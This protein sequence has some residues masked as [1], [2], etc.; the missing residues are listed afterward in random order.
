MVTEH[1]EDE[2]RHMKLKQEIEEIQRGDWD[3]RLQKE[4]DDRRRSQAFSRSTA[5]GQSK[6]SVVVPK[7]TGL[8][9]PP[10]SRRDGSLKRS[11]SPSST[12]IDIPKT[13]P[14]SLQ[15]QVHPAIITQGRPLAAQPG[16]IN[17]TGQSPYRPNPGLSPLPSQGQP[18]NPFG[19]PVPGSSTGYAGRALIPHG[20]PHGRP[21][22]PMPP[23]PYQQYAQSPSHITPHVTYGVRPANSGQ[24]Q[25]I[26]SPHPSQR[27]G[28]M[29]PPFQVAPQPPAPLQ[30]QQASG[31]APVVPSR[32]G[33]KA[34]IDTQAENISTPL[35]PKPQ[36]MPTPLVLSISKMLSNPSLNSTPVSSPGAAKRLAET[37]W[38]ETPDAAT[39]SSPSRPRSRSVSP[40][41]EQA[42]SPEADTTSKKRRKKAAPNS[43]SEVAASTR[44]AR[45]SRR[46]RGASAASSV[47]ESS[48]RGR[49]RSQSM[50]TAT[51]EHVPKQEPSTPME[52]M[53]IDTPMRAP[54]SA[55]RNI[56]GKRKRSPT[57]TSEQGDQHETIKSTAIP[58]TSVFAVRNFQRLSS[59]VMN[60]IMSHKH[61]SIF[62]NPVRD[63]HAEG[64][65]SMIRRPSDL[66]S[67]KA[68]ISFGSRAANAANVDVDSSVSA[69]QL[70]W[71]E[72][73]VPPKGIV[74]SAQ[75]EKELMR[76]FAN[77]VMFNPGEED[78]VK[79]ARE[80][81]ESA[82]ASLLNF[83]SAEQRTEAGSTST[84]GLRKRAESEIST[85]VNGDD[86]PTM[87]PMPSG[88]GKRRK[89]AQL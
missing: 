30:Q 79:D 15:A 34:T 83:K 9:Q 12:N 36:A 63:T 59:A 84:S 46:R 75:L 8:L 80:M 25:G 53:D 72:D 69:A 74:N 71:S 45:I 49:T 82:E 56:R 39:L 51:S 14:R 40:I 26:I 81:C 78:V 48:V 3:A 2:R 17:T 88:I 19:Q 41:S 58:R 20:T 7:S 68:W 27:G 66:K 23:S 31:Q 22:V 38:K 33:Q 35:A 44:S 67:I 6:S 42:P 55:R 32:P 16:P 18:H 5:P 57:A 29:L 43:T 24:H 73:L 62:S 4:L 10:Q 37:R 52:P 85:Q 60:D 11:P 50:E 47:L 77:A 54:S 21:H 64:Y 76:M 61:A 28:I 65:S 13:I 89:V 70:P 1:R 87:L 86:E